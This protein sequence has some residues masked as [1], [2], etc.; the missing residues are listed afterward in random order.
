MWNLWIRG[1]PI[2]SNNNNNNNNKIEWVVCDG[3]REDDSN[4]IICN[5]WYHQECIKEKYK[6]NQFYWNKQLCFGHNCK[7]SDWF[8]NLNETTKEIVVENIS[9]TRNVKKKTK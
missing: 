8:R 4:S 1:D 6:N 7:H 3:P 2:L 9:F 5:Q